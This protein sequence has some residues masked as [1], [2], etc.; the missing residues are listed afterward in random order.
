MPEAAALHRVVDRRGQYPRGDAEA[1]C[2]NLR[3]PLEKS[4][5]ELDAL[6]LK[7]YGDWKQKCGLVLATSKDG[8]SEYVLQADKAAFEEKGVE[9]IVSSQEMP[10]S[11]A[12]EPPKTS[13]SA[14]PPSPAQ[15]S[16][17]N[18]LGGGVSASAKENSYACCSYNTC[19]LM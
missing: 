2:D 3:A 4:I 11:P 1:L 19:A 17:N 16:A 5:E 9:L 12:K 7:D 15:R 18:A 14:M 10:S 6:L 8:K 13:A